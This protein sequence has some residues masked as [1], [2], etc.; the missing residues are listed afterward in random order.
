MNYFFS[1]CFLLIPIIINWQFPLPFVHWPIS[2]LALVIFGTH[3][4]N[5]FIVDLI[6]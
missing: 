1:A 2:L 5:K 3:T 4:S 6:D